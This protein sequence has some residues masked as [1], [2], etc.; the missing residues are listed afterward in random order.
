MSDKNESDAAAGVESKSRISLEQNVISLRQELQ[1]LYDSLKNKNAQLMTL[2]KDITE[3]DVFIKN[4]KEECKKLRNSSQCSNNNETLTDTC[5]NCLKKI[6]YESI[7]SKFQKQVEDRDNSIQELNK[8]IIRLS[9]NLI[10]V[11]K[12]SLSKNDKID[13]LTR[14][15]DKFR[16]VVI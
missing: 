8:K 5:K 3:R 6:S 14:Q 9:E 13:E 4:L 16:Q 15:I 11:Q 12:E 2:E 1:I 7:Q 10:F